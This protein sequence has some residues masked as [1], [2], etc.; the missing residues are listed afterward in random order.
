[1]T[2]LNASE[3]ILIFMFVDLFHEQIDEFKFKCK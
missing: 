3:E 2:A 1:M